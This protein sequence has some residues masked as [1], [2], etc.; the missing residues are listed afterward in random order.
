M[1][2]KDTIYIEYEDYRF[3]TRFDIESGAQ[4]K[5]ERNS[6]RS[7]KEEISESTSSIWPRWEYLYIDNPQQ[8]GKSFDL[9]I[10]AFN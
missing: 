6:T 10:K 5:N 4:A 2:M 3:K 8:H 9:S 1:Y 7:L